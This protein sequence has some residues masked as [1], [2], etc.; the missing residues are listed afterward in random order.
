MIIQHLLLFV[1]LC[2]IIG[3]KPKPNHRKRMR[4]YE[5]AYR[6]PAQKA[7]GSDT[8]ALYQPAGVIKPGTPQ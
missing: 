3:R 2:F 4:A 6:R 5:A 7:L 1:C 8:V